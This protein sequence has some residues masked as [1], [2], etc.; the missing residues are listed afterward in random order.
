MKFEVVATSWPTPMRLTEVEANCKL[1]ALLMNRAY[2]RL[3]EAGLLASSASPL[4]KTVWNVRGNPLVLNQPVTVRARSECRDGLSG[5]M[6]TSSLPSNRSALPADAGGSAGA[7]AA[8]A[9]G[10]A[11]LTRA[12]PP[13]SVPSLWLAV[14]STAVAPDASSKRQQPARPRLGPVREL[15]PAARVAV[16]RPGA[17]PTPAP[18]VLPLDREPAGGKFPKARLP[19]KS[20]WVLGFRAPG[21]ATAPWRTPLT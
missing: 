4:M 20:G 7:G 13:L 2:S 14:R 10:A 12:G 1:P 19:M 15:S 3:D 5:M 6:T 17:V 8:A 11:G 18:V 16:R 9:T 21:L